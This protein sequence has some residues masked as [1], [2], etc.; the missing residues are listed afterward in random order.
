MDLVR[1]FSSDV[2]IKCRGC[3]AS[4]IRSPLSRP[5]VPFRMR[6]KSGFS[7]KVAIAFCAVSS[8]LF[9]VAS[10]PIQAAEVV[11]ETAGGETIQGQWAGATDNAVRIDD[12]DSAREVL[13]DQLVSLRL[14]QSPGTATGPSLAVTLVDGTLIMTQDIT[15]DEAEV[16]I[17]PRRQEVIRMPI[18][19][20]RSIR[21]RLGTPATDPQWLGLVDQEMRS[22]LMVIRRGNDQL[23]PIEGVVVGLDPQNLLFELDGDKI[24]A[25]RDRLEGVFFRSTAGTESSPKVKISDV[26]G[27][28]FHANRLESSDARD[29]VE[30]PLAGGVRHSIPIDQI[31]VIAWSS[32]RQMLA[33]Q[34]AASSQM[35]PYLRTG[36]PENLIKDWFEPTAEGDDL[37][38]AAGGQIDFRVEE[39]FQTF[40]GSVGR[41]AA[42]A[43]GGAVVVRL[44]VDDEVRWEQTLVDSEPKGFRLPVGGARRVRLEV[45]AGDDGDVGDQVRF[46]KPRLLK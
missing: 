13:V 8:L 3:F 35:V 34:V 23:D 36:L 25:P 21:F 20:V 41:D 15:M 30:I 7:L 14:A 46:L 42:V 24:E 22:D 12:G 5:T 10:I 29:A 38:A 32:G 18:K 27:S 6:F 9:G 26:Y 1:S 4:S 43:A 2:V 37:V 31:K 28:I 11:L 33:R 39:G 16:K 44:S 45:L 40:A 19:Q 17:E